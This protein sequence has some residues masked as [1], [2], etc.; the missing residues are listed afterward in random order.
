VPVMALRAVFELESR[1]ARTYRSR[2]LVDG[3]S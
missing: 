1:A 3:N 2:L